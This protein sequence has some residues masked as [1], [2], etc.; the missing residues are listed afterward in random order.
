MGTMLRQTARYLL[1]TGAL[2]VLISGEAIPAAESVTPQMVAGTQPVAGRTA[3]RPR[4]RSHP[5][6]VV[7]VAKGW[8]VWLGTPTNGEPY[9][10]TL[11]DIDGDGAAEI[12][13]HAGETFALR[14][15]GTFL[16][17]WPKHE[18]AGMGYGTQGQLPGP[19][20]G[21]LD[22]DGVPE[23][24]W[25]T[26]DW[27]A[28]PS[29]TWA[30]NVRRRDGSDLPGFPQ[31]A[32]TPDASALFIPFVLG[33]PR[34]PGFL[35]AAAALLRQP[36]GD[37]ELTFFSAAGGG[38]TTTFLAPGSWIVSLHFGDLDGDGQGEFFAVSTLSGTGGG[39]LHAF[40][41][42]GQEKPGYPKALPGSAQIADG[43][44]AADLD[45]DGDLEVLTGYVSTTSDGGN[46]GCF[47]H[48]GTSCQ[49]FPL[50]VEPG[51][52]VQ[53]LSLGNVTGGSWPDDLV[54]LGWDRLASVYRLFVMDLS[55][56]ALLAGWP[57]TLPGSTSVANLPGAPLVVDVD[58][59]G[60][61]DV[62][63]AHVDGKLYAFSGT[64]SLLPGYPATMRSSSISGAAAGDIDGDG[65][66]EIVAATWDGWVYAW[67]TNAPARADLAD[68]PMARADARNT[69]VY[70]NPYAALP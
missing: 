21:D 8:P 52:Q 20:V 30:F 50:R 1:S 70:R 57:V 66:L 59:D 37:P 5:G 56:G 14:G 61:Q 62:V 44:I 26:R 64:G 51:L 29:R 22:G 9:T 34:A 41:D 24:L 43:P 2:L 35:S 27:Y 47:H 58:G 32:P 15:D 12:F 16:P 67:K 54:V 19:S 48:D 18:M 6:R 53:Q 69:G 7:G 11:F 36:S 45:G 68:W 39:S 38:R 46:V 23:V 40:D 55:T 28:G 4:V 65:L 25:A 3:G 13:V 31:T 10:P 60:A 17:G 33:E 42:Q 63:V 49:G